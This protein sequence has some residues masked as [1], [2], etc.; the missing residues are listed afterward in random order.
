MDYPEGV[1]L[2]ELLGIKIADK[3]REVIG[4]LSDVVFS[5]EKP[6]EITKFIAGG[7]ALEEFLEKIKLKTD[8]DP[9]F[10]AA[11]IRSFTKSSIF[12]NKTHN[13]L[14]EAE[15][16]ENTETRPEI[17][18]TQLMKT[19]VIGKND[20][21]VGNIIDVHFDHDSVQFILGGGF[22]RDLIDNIGLVNQDEFLIREED[23]IQ[24][25]NGLLKI[26]KS[27]TDLEK[28]ISKHKDHTDDHL[29]N[30]EDAEFAL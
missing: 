2:S 9:V 4:S 1:N 17:R 14:K 15:E 5:L 22:F 25:S 11:D 21:K 6:I 29:A 3:N 23:I 28:V 8:R 13:R 18:F 7:T 24:F 19:K 20:Q 12:L 27:K 30:F 16:Q 10:N 26:S